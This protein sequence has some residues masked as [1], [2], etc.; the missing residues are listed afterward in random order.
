MKRNDMERIERELKRQQKKERLGE[1]RVEDRPPQSIGA[2]IKELKELLRHDG[3]VIYNTLDD[4]DVLE[5]LENM[6]DDIPEHKWET[7]IRKA[8]NATKVVEREPALKELWSLVEE[9]MGQ[10]DDD[11][12][13]EEEEVELKAAAD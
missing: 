3:K 4:E 5:C 1:K 6:K 12:D 9:D 11:E 2:Y 10:D 8:V 7:V 13:D